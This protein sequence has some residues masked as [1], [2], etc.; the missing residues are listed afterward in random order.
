MECESYPRK[1]SIVRS[2]MVSF[3]LLFVYSFVDLICVGVC[4]MSL[5]FTRWRAQLSSYIMRP[6]E[7][8]KQWL[9]RE[10]TL[11]P[12]SS[13]IFSAHPR[14]SPLTDHSL[15][16][17][18][19]QTQVPSP[20]SSISFNPLIQIHRTK[21]LSLPPKFAEEIKFAKQVQDN[22]VVDIVGDCCWLL[23]VY[24][25]NLFSPGLHEFEH[26][27][28]FIEELSNELQKRTKKEERENGEQEEKEKTRKVFLASDD[29]EIKDYMKDFSASPAFLYDS[30]FETE[31]KDL[32]LHKKLQSN[33]NSGFPPSSPLPFPL[34]SYSAT[35]QVASVT[36]L[37]DQ[38]LT[39]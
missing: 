31:K 17:S 29:Q 39:T 35:F 15:H 28:K 25:L 4:I 3:C 23:L 24:C 16:Q 22:T 13:S 20:F 2:F 6:N 7:R 33:I 1:I 30:F 12:V 26:Y 8:V 9:A 36:E 14:S 19:Y 32:Q 34:F 18:L 10:E 38:G 27:H 21:N 37:F 11:S 5:I